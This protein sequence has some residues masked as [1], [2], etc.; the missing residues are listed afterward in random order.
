MLSARG[1][2]SWP[3]PPLQAC[4]RAGGPRREGRWR[5]PPETHP[6]CISELT[7]IYATRTELNM[8]DLPRKSLQY[9][10]PSRSALSTLC[11]AGAQLSGWSSRKK[12]AYSPV[13]SGKSYQPSDA[14]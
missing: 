14:H 8:S 6:P 1:P 10:Y 13:I 7:V 2:W 11:S 3:S 5:E 4:L 12:K 9:L